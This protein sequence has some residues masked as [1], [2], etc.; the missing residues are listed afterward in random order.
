MP[1]ILFSSLKLAIQR[2]GQILSHLCVCDLLVQ[3]C[4]VWGQFSFL[5]TQVVLVWCWLLLAGLVQIHA[6]VSAVPVQQCEV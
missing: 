5:T 6:C 4:M 1:S 2:R 3:R